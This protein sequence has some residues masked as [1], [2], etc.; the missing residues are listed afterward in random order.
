MMKYILLSLV[1]IPMTLFTQPSGV[2][3]GK[4]L[5]LNNRKQLASANIVLKGTSTGTSSAA[6]GTFRLSVPVGRQLI[7]VSFVGFETIE[8][9]VEV[10]PDEVMDVE[11]LL[12]PKILPGQT[13]VVT[14]TRGK[15]RETPATFST[16]EAKELATRYNTQDIPQLLSELPSTTFYSDNGN[17]IGYT[18][19]NIRGFDQ[20]RISVMINGIPQNDPEDHN[21]Y[22]L[23]FPDLAANLEDIQVQRGAGSAFY[24][25][26]AIGGSVNL[27]TSSFA[28][29]PGITASSGIGTFNTR[30]YSVKANSGLVANRYAF[31]AKL[32]RIISDG[33]RERSWADF[34]SY[35]LGAVRYDET[36]TTQLN[37][38]GGPVKDHLAYYGISKQDA[39]SSD[40]TIRRANPIQRPEEIE[41]FSQPHYELLHEWKLNETVTLNNS[42]FYVTGEGFFDYDGSWAPYSYYRIT[43]QNG[44]AVTGD[45]DTLY[46]AN[47]LIRAWV[48]NRQFGWLPRA[49]I[50]HEGGELTVGVELRRHRSLH[51]GALRWGEGLPIG[52]TPE[53]HYYEYNG[54]KEMFSLYAHEVWRIQPNLTL[55]ADLQYAYNKYRLYNER[56]LG[57][58]FSVPYHFVNP[59]LGVNYNVTSKLNIYA[60]VSRTSREPRLKN[61]Y[62]AAE[63]SYPAIWGIVEPQFEQRPGGGYDFSKPLVKPEVLT[64]LELGGGY[65]SP[66][67]RATAN[68]FLMDFSNEIIKSGQL[69]RFGQPVTGNAEKTRHIGIELTAT[70]RIGY[71]EFHGNMTTSRNRLVKYTVFDSGTPQSLD[72]NTIAGFPEVI[73]NVRA[74]FSNEGLSAVLSMQHVGDFYTDNF[75][76]PGKGISDPARTVDAY[77]VFHAWL[78]YR[79]DPGL[80]QSVEMRLQVSNLF[81]AIYASHGEGDDFF[82]AATKNVFGSIQIVL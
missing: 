18:Y 37:F 41:N 7:A 20:R 47:A 50:K 21:V 23:D 53:Y 76:N 43:P 19:L 10:R 80:G 73:A 34:S 69:D 62:D 39:Y 14:S 22:W 52:V 35:F 71:F 60:Q 36:M 32:S 63:A 5:E 6:D 74:S 66:D 9:E 58:D 24:G 8:R 67:F 29:S 78:N 72:G 54:A 38:Y 26:A 75:Q 31:Q 61:L 79:F 25:P 51:W 77:T 12:S 15:E 55:M 64:D 81:D 11:F 3:T 33:Y 59:R 17:G 70:A 28:S 30:K 1:S 68:F 56:Y 13:I 27:I 46:I 16:L 45:P 40:E 2:L 44:F 65:I 42:L 4:V 48:G 82:P 57:T 49:T